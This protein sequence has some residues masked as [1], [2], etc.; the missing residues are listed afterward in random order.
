MYAH[1]VIC[2]WNNI[3]FGVLCLKIDSRSLPPAKIINM[4]Q[5]QIRLQRNRQ[6]CSKIDCIDGD[7]YKN[8]LEL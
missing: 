7:R 3:C 8:L 2:V 1:K 6:V 5:Q 4:H